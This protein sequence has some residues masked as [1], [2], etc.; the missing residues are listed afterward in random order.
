MPNDRAISDW[1]SGF[2]Q[3]TENTEPPVSF[4]LWTAI[5]V[6]ASALQRKCFVSLGPKEAGALVF[7]PN[8][9]ILLVGP[10]AVRKGTAMGP[11]KRLLTDTGINLSAEATTRQQLIRKFKAVNGSS[12][13]PHT[14]MMHFHSSLT[15]FSKEFTVFLGYHNHELM[16]HLCDWYDC[17]DEWEYETV[18]RGKEKIIGVW[19]NLMGA[20]T[21][22]LIQSSMP[23]D[24]IGGGLTSRM[25]MV[26][27]E[28]KAK[29]VY[30]PIVTAEEAKLYVHLKNDL[31]KIQLQRGNHQFTQGFIDNWISWRQ[32]QEIK[33]PDFS[34]NRFDGYINRRPNHVIKLCMIFSASER[35]DMILKEGDLARALAALSQV[36]VN[37]PRVFSGVGKSDLASLIPPVAAF[38]QKRG[39][40]TVGEIM[41][42]FVHD[43]DSWTLKNRILQALEDMGDI[44]IINGKSIQWIEKEG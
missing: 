12:A 41:S 25:I 28:K 2:M 13:D 32:S 4:R 14:G 16:S 26:Y 29:A 1:I 36:E 27:E 21:P 38:I 19:L 33:P 22:A 3:L 20:T 34:D 30:L 24:A 31:E 35:G 10:S 18:A 5:S 44:Q 40:T 8:M 42:V 39:K 7:Y 9:Y 43:L 6:V 15:I 17:E 23:L 11:G 37:M